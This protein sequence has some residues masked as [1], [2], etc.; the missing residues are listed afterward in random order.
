MHVRVS[1]QVVRSSDGVSLMSSY[2]V[3]LYKGLASLLIVS[4]FLVSY[5]FYGVFGYLLF[6]GMIHVFYYGV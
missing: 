6:A 1:M 2:F 5:L 3:W 4:E